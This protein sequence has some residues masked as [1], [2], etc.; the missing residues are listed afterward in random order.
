M[1]FQLRMSDPTRDTHVIDDIH[2]SPYLNPQSQ[3]SPAF[4]NSSAR[5]LDQ[6]NA[7]TSRLLAFPSSFGHTKVSGIGDNDR[8][9]HLWDA[10]LRLL[11]YCG[12]VCAGRCSAL[13]T[14]LFQTSVQE[15][16]HHRVGPKFF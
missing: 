2:I 16:A 10:C 5:I 8:N 15:G 7:T 14:A 3:L 4:S 9:L 12:T 11:G 13:C 6:L 1:E